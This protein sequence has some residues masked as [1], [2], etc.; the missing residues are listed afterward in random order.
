LRDKGTL[1]Q[2]IFGVLEF[3][4]LSFYLGKIFILWFF[5]SLPFEE[6]NDPMAI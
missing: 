1:M 2:L 4:L 6:K 3:S 5:R